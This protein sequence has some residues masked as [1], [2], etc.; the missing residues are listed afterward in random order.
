MVGCM[1]WLCAFPRALVAECMQLFRFY[2]ALS[3]QGRQHDGLINTNN[4][5][6]MTVAFVGDVQEQLSMLAHEPAWT[7]ARL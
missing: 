6:R 2:H 7:L 3:H 1:L 5:G 4:E